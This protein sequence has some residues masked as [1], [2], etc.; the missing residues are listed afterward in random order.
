[1]KNDVW[2]KGSKTWSRARV[3]EPNFYDEQDWLHPG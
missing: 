2:L 3:D 1:M